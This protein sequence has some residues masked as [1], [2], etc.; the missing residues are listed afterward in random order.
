MMQRLAAQEHCREMMPLDNRGTMRMRS[1]PDF[2]EFDMNLVQTLVF[3]SLPK[4]VKTG[5]QL[6]DQQR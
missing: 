2:K 5:G 1:Q 3:R 6:L 4:Y